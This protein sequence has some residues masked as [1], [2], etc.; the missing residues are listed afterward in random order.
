M[1]ERF[2]CPNC[3][4][5]LV[6]DPGVQAL[7]CPYCG[8]VQQIDTAKAEAKVEEKSFRE[9][10]GFVVPETMLAT[11][12]KEAICKGCGG[13][14]QFVPPETATLCPFCGSA[15]VAQQG[16]ANPLVAPQGVL[17]F[18][19]AQQNVNQLMRQWLQ[20]LW[21]APSG[22]AQ[23]A[24]PDRMQGVYVPYWTYD[25]A[26]QTNYRGQRGDHYYETHY[27]TQRMADGSTQ[28]VPVQVRKTRWR[29]VDGTVY[30]TFDDVLV[31]A[32]RTVQPDRLQALAPWDLDQ[33]QAY[34]P[35][36]LSGFK[37]QRYQVDLNQ[38]F[39]HAQQLMQ[40]PIQR[41]IRQDIGG[42]EQQI[43]AMDVH[44]GNVS[45]KH[46]LFPVWI[47]AYHFNGKLYQVLINAR[48]GEVQGERPWSAIKIALA[49]LLV[50]LVLMIGI[51]FAQR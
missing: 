23:L 1:P 6:F 36:Y 13:A 20:G 22:L 32:T 5:G 7:Q 4:A 45:F 44:Y 41:T 11:N 3:S 9:F 42:D 49:V 26:T 21:F 14:V 33:I 35:A 27:Q 8:T 24:R 17:P 28:Q 40:G 30:N 38:G 47:A 34:Q 39:G 31:P 25:A 10:Q 48:T 37:A 16:A 43:E 50:L 46:L 51:V 2:T 15:Q 12:A 18:R 29:D 19:V